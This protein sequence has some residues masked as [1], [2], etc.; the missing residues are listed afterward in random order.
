MPL[1]LNNCSS[2]ASQYW[3]PLLLAYKAIY[4]IL[5]LLLAFQTYSVK[6]KKLRDSKLI[7][8]S[9]FVIVVVS[10]VLTVI[11][12]F[13]NNDPNAFYG[14]LGCFVLL[15]ITGVVGLLFIPRVRFLCCG[16]SHA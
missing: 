13:V 16:T 15:P 8:I 10:V 7:V 9:V 11:G 6:I 1:L 14:L 4:L 2:R 3:L 5:G 12:F